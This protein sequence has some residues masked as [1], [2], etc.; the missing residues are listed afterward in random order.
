MPTT[1][2]DYVDSLRRE[3]TP[4]GDEDPYSEVE[5]T[6]LTGHLVDAFWEARLDGFMDGWRAGTDGTMT[7]DSGAEADFPRE[8]VALIVTY[9]GI[10]ILRLRLMNT[11]SHFKASAGPVEFE[12]RNSA[13][14]MRELLR[15]LQ[16]RKEKFLEA[17]E[18]T[19]VQVIDALTVRTL[20]V[21]SY[22][23]WV[24]QPVHY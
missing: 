19:D 21:G 7:R 24:D 12:T 11:E 15:Q 16:W 2:A 13:E 6:K 23:G 8:K 20:S 3:I 1:L 22:G 5:N 14:V 4:L 9:A 18:R 10:R 17:L